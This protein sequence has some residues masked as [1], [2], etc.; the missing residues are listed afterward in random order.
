M[1]KFKFWEKSLPFH[2]RSEKK[3]EKT[4]KVTITIPNSGFYE[5]TINGVG[6]GNYYDSQPIVPL[7]TPVPEPVEVFAT[8]E[9]EWGFGNE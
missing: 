6:Y 3:E 1:A 2:K 4:E 5:W 9:E 8:K 7:L